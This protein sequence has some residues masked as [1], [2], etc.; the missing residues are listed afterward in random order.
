VQNPKI[1]NERTNLPGSKLVL[2]CLQ[3]GQS[4]SSPQLG[5]DN[6][7][8]IIWGLLRLADVI[9]DV[10]KLTQLDADQN[11]IQT[12]LDHMLGGGAVIA[13]PDV[14]LERLGEVA[15]RVV[16]IADVVLAHPDALID[17]ISLQVSK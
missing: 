4:S 13:G 10:H 7:I 9:G 2:V 8:Q 3:V 14:A 15:V 11:H 17:H 12:H 6:G 16:E 5:E 1:G